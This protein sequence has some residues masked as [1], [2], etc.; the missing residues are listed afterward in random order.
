[1]AAWAD[2]SVSCEMTSESEVDV[3]VMPGVNDWASL[4]V[5]F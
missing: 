4:G 2:V 5:M 3:P 1:M